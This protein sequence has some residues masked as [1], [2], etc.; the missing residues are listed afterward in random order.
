MEGNSTRGDKN[1]HTAVAIVTNGYANF[2]LS[3]NCS[4]G[5][6]NCFEIYRFIWTR[7]AP[8]FEYPQTAFFDVV[9]DHLPLSIMRLTS[10]MFRAREEC[11]L[12]SQR[13]REKQAAVAM[14]MFAA[15]C[16]RKYSD[17]NGYNVFKWFLNQ[18]LSAFAANQSS[19]QT[20]IQL[21]TSRADMQEV[22][23]YFST[24]FHNNPTH[25]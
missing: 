23:F 11:E 10:T 18:Q 8:R 2:M 25:N 9:I 7:L 20:I 22:R 5:K 3:L 12:R 21:F 19:F 14:A 4:S 1:E 24:L 17:F 16:F 6:W 13:L 15:L